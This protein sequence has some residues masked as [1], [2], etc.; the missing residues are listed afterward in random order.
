M[1]SL[2]TQYFLEF[3]SHKLVQ[4]RT[5]SSSTAHL[6][7]PNLHHKVSKTYDDHPNIGSFSINQI[8]NNT[9]GLATRTNTQ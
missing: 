1:D 7:L 4:D 6:F 9:P 2:R 8:G 3:L 5:P